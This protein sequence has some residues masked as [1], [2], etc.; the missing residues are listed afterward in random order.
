MRR[1]FQPGIDENFNTFNLDAFL[2]WDFRLGSRVVFG[3]KNWL[4]DPYSVNG[5]MYK[6]YTE[7]LG[8]TMRNSHGN[9]LTLKVIYFL[10]VNQLKRKR[11]SP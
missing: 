11:A 7:N 1:P 5:I 2:T 6:H 10:D 3:W 9:E 8:Q 4:G